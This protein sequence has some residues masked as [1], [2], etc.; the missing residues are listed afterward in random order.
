[1]QKRTS[2][3]WHDL[4]HLTRGEVVAELLI[5]LPWLLGSLVL[6]SLQAYALALACSFMFFLTGLRQVH[7][8][9]HFALGIRKF[10]T[11]CVMVLLSALMLGSMHAV[12]VNH[13][14][15]HRHCL[16]RDDVEAMSARMAWWQAIAI[17]PVFPV[18]LHVSA[19]RACTPNQRFLIIAELS[20]NV[21]VLALV[22]L[23]LDFTS[24]QYHFYAMAI[25]QCLTAFFAVWTVHHGS[26][27]SRPVNRTMRS[28]LLGDLT[29]NMFLHAEH[30][31]FPAVPT[32][33]LPE[34]ARRLDSVEPGLFRHRVL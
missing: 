29:Y 27:E 13:L 10:Q 25:G 11:H 2:V 21:A 34:L 24:L 17:G 6:A 23:V 22:F 28:W 20:A 9:F 3:Q 16:G 31:L 4:L 15:H 8:A 19:L 7:N 26:T 14:R 18:I 32:R 12:Q 5:S 1:M 30:H 33:K